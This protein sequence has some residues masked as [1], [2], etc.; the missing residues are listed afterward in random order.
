MPSSDTA[1]T[2][3]TPA[4][5]SAA[6][7]VRPARDPLLTSLQSG[8]PTALAHLM[9]SH[10][11]RLLAI[12]GQLAGTERGAG[13]A[14]QSAIIEAWRQAPAVPHGRLSTEAWLVTLVRGEALRAARSDRAARTPGTPDGIGSPAARHAMEAWLGS[15]A[16]R[17]AS[18]TDDPGAELVAGL[19]EL[20]RQHGIAPPPRPH[21]QAALL[22][23]L[24]VGRSSSEETRRA[25]RLVSADADAR[26]TYDGFVEALCQQALTIEPVEVPDGLVEAA[27]DQAVRTPR[28]DAG[29]AMGAGGGMV[30]LFRG[31]LAPVL[32]AALAMVVVIA[33]AQQRQ[34][35]AMSE[36]LDRTAE[37]LEARETAGG[38]LAPATVHDLDTTGRFGDAALQVLQWDGLVLLVARDVPEP[39]PG[40][41][42]QAW[43]T[44]RTGGGEVRSRPLVELPAGSS[45]SALPADVDPGSTVSITDEATGGA[46]VRPTG[47]RAATGTLDSSGTVPGT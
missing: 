24:A 31:A 5:A 28:L 26:D 43:A 40:R 47:A 9:A 6:E 45:V 20:V 17:T 32:G 1:T 35:A 25:R 10:A 19:D 29:S 14:L 44:V 38:L 8:D 42:W 11:P 33:L 22:A 23:R 34:L 7:A 13:A 27:I 3:G 30:R 16:S 37:E 15:D 36:R 4:A 39:G 12:A 21:G 18:D 2:P 41:T 46:P